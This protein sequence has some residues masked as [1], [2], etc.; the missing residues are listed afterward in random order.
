MKKYITIA[1]LIG[2]LTYSPINVHASTKTDELDFINRMISVLKVLDT[3]DIRQ[4]V[5]LLSDRAKTLEHEVELEKREIR[6]KTEIKVKDTKEVI[7]QLEKPKCIGSGF[8]CSIQ[9]LQ[10]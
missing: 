2:V 10:A 5:I 3:P 9:T 8:Q 7:K 6:K 4:I 1:V